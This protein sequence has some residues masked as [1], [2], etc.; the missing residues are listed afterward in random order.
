MRFEKPEES[1]GGEG[2]KKILNERALW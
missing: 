2:N 1:W